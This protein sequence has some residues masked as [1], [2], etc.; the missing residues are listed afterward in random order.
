MNFKKIHPCQAFALIILFLV[1]ACSEKIA[2][3]YFLHVDSLSVANVDYSIHGSV[4]SKI[5]DI[6]VY[7]D[8]TLIGA[9][10]LP[11]N[12]PIINNTD[13]KVTIWGGIS[14]N[15]I[16][17]RRMEY[18][19]Y[20]FNTYDLNWPSGTYKTLQPELKYRTNTKLLIHE[21]FEA[22]TNFETQNNSAVINSIS[23][24]EKL[25]GISSGIVYLDELNPQ[26]DILIQKELIL[27]TNQ[28][29]FLELNYKS[30]V[31]FE[32]DL[33]GITNTGSTINALGGVNAK[34]N[35]NKIYFNVTNL[36]N[37]VH[38]NKYKLNIRSILPTGKTNAFVMLDN[39]KLLSLQ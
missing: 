17:N 10:V 25:E 32:V 13:K 30:D 29:Y 21:D 19:F 28:T 24:S 27:F 23:N 34:T 38:A 12:I 5:T 22:G 2:V 37:S 33:I 6:W 7:S 8:N 31:P 3:P 18:P 14:E 16:D 20:T 9:Y 36:V 39:I 26:M 4:N 11:A 15:G 1:S 35:W